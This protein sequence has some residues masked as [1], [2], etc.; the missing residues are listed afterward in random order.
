MIGHEDVCHRYAIVTNIVC[1]D[2]KYQVI[3]DG[4]GLFSPTYNSREEAIK[5]IEDYCSEHKT[6]I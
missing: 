2:I 4:F 6:N 1:Y 3:G 5:A